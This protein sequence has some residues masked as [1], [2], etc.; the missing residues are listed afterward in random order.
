MLFSRLTACSSQIKI[1]TIQISI[2][3]FGIFQIRNDKRNKLLKKISL[4]ERG[5]IVAA[6]VRPSIT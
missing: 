1:T 2:D 4:L 6:Q 5:I 3:C